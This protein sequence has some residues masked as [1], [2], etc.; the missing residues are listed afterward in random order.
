MRKAFVGAV[1]FLTLQAPVAQR[2]DEVR[3]AS[4][5]LSLGQ[6]V[7]EVKARVPEGVRLEFV[8]DTLPGMP[9]GRP[10]EN[11][12]AYESWPE[13]RDRTVRIEYSDEHGEHAR[14]VVENDPTAGA[15]L[16][17]EE[18]KLTRISRLIGAENGHTAEAGTVMRSLIG[19]LSGWDSEAPITVSTFEGSGLREISFVSGQRT[20]TVLERPGFLQVV[21][22]VGRGDIETVTTHP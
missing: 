19:A 17:F 10:T 5:V 1:L 8:K 12:S 15:F 16:V 4:V 21:E 14:L 20:L 2:A 13:V 22:N 9:A 3:L 11:G 6:T 7:S 18:G